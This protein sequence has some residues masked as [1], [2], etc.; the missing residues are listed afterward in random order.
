MYGF[1]IILASGSPRRYQL[2]KTAGFDVHVVKSE[3]KETIDSRAKDFGRV[4]MDLARQ[5]AMDVKSKITVGNEILLAADTMVV[6]DDK[7][8]GKPA[9]V[10][11][12]KSCLH[13]LSGKRHEVITGVYMS[14]GAQE[15]LFCVRTAV[16]F[17][18]LSNEMINYY[19]ETCKPLDKAGAYGIQE[20]IG[21]VGIEKIEGDYFNVVGLPVQKVVKTVEEFFEM[22]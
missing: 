1:K 3:L 14:F 9:N 10:E 22:N 5:K 13:L 15:R 7:A 20:W 21:M 17:A 6:M 18:K 2:L 8:L 16:Y 19:V 4:S 11:D 12:A